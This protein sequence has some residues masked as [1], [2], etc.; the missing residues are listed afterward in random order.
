MAFVLGCSKIGSCV[1]MNQYDY[2]HDNNDLFYCDH[3]P[4]ESHSDIAP[5]LKLFAAI[6]NRGI[7]DACGMTSLVP[8]ARV[9]GAE[10]SRDAIEARAWI[11]DDSMQAFRFLWLAEALDITDRQVDIIRGKVCKND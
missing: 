5:E 11:L 9:A 3:E 10:N 8:F 7:A 4:Y 1:V 2:E 6:M